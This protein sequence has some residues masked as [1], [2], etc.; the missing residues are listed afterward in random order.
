MDFKLLEPESASIGFSL[1]YLTRFG[2]FDCDF[3]NKFFV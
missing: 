1:L 3:A 2:A